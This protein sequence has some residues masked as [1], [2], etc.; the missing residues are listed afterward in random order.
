MTDY[1]TPKKHAEDTPV[2]GGAVAPEE[3]R[4]VIVRLDKRYRPRGFVVPEVASGPEDP[5]AWVTREEALELCA[6]LSARFG[7]LH[8]AL[9]LD[10]DR[11]LRFAGG[12]L[13]GRLP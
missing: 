6:V 13:L 1:A 4:W 10:R 2:N 5:L 11:N 9:Y 7:M 3:R 12:E 8:A